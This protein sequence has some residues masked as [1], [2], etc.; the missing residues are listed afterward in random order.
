MNFLD[1]K[2]DDQVNKQLSLLEQN[3]RIPHAILVDGADKQAR[4]NF[5][6]FLSMW[7]VCNSNGDKPCGVCR[8]CLNAR[9]H[10]HADVKFIEGSGKTNSISVDSIR[11]I[12]ADCA[13]IPNEADT[14]VYIIDDADKRMSAISQNAF[15][16]TLEEPPANVLFLLSCSDNNAMLETVRSRATQFTLMAKTN[17]NQDNVAIAEKLAF[18]IINSGEYNLLKIIF[19]IKNT[20]DLDAIL[21][22][23]ALLFRD[24]LMLVNGANTELNSAVSVTVSK[25]ITREKIIAIIDVVASARLKIKQNVNTNLLT[26]WL[27]A[28]FRRKIWQ[29]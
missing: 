10:R 25:N 3:N 15:L 6:D 12:T 1:F 27:C 18:G 23:V 9:H 28:E 2:F 14:K 4:S 13:V 21:D 17:Y 11:A 20:S 26:T 16:K 5:C 19:S 29:K 7:A 8:A 24:A 22:L